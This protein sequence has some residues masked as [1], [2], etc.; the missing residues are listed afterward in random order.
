[1]EEQKT[2]VQPSNILVPID[3]ESFPH[4]IIRLTGASISLNIVH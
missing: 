2:L 1:M 3:I 4:A